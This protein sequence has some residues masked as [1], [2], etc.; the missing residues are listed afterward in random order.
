[1]YALKL[2][3][4]RLV[5]YVDLELFY[6]QTQSW[7]YTQLS[8]DLFSLHLILK[9]TPLFLFLLYLEL[10]MPLI[11]SRGGRCVAPEFGARQ[12]APGLLICHSDQ[13]FFVDR[14]QLVPNLQPAVLKQHKYTETF[15]PWCSTGYSNRD[16]SKCF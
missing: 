13:G 7:I 15:R 2:N 16:Q 11:K 8:S 4:N 12:D 9:P 3:Q 6:T 5:E 14:H 1:M 10:F